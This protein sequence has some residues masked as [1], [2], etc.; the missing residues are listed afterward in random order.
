MSQTR[1][2]NIESAKRHL[3][4]KS[5]PRLQVSLILGL[6]GLA[7]LLTSFS[8]LHAG[9]TWMWIRY[10]IAILV[11]YGAFL[12]MLRLW[13]WLQHQSWDAAVDPTAIDIYPS[14]A[15]DQGSSFQFGGGGDFGGVVLAAVGLR[16]PLHLHPQA[17]VPLPKASALI[18]IWKK[19][20][21]WCLRWSPSSEV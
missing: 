20:G 8:L 9:I 12:L 4:R 19:A 5:S 21:W 2:R 16:A 1:E 18:W 6:T 17:E 13:L 11:A 14:V 3:L 15:S 10:S 7:G